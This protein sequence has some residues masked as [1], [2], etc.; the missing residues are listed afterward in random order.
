M[1]VD[2]EFAAVVRYYDSMLKKHHRRLASLDRRGVPEADREE[3]YRSIRKYQ[4][5]I[6]A[7][8]RFEETELQK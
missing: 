1:A 3:T 8:K 2:E 6:A 5:V 7:L 4:I